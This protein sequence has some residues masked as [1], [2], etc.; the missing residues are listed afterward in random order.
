[1]S[2]IEEVKKMEV[3]RLSIVHA[4]CIFCGYHGGRYWL[5]HSH[6]ES[7][8]WYEISGATAREDIIKK[9]PLVTQLFEPKPSSKSLT[10]KEIESELEKH[11]IN[12]PLF[13][14]RTCF[15]HGYDYA[16]SGYQTRKKSKAK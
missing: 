10:P 15:R 9:V 14:H 8:P 5:R 11:N 4:P 1:M 12:H 16:L 6:S 7:C 3:L 2:K 13:S